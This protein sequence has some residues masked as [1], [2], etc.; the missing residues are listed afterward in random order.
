MKRQDQTDQAGPDAVEL[1]Q[2][3]VPG[4]E[5]TSHALAAHVMSGCT[6]PKNQVCSLPRQ[7]YLRSALGRVQV[8]D[9][10]ASGGAG[11]RGRPLGP[12]NLPCQ[13]SRVVAWT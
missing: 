3:L 7:Q 2:W 5:E 11:V 13:D 12:P 10:N 4:A 6:P 8:N 9:A 1:Q